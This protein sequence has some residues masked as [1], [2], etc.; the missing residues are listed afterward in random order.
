MKRLL[1]ASILLNSLFPIYILYERQS[2]KWNGHSLTQG[3]DANS[4][5]SLGSL[6][7]QFDP[8]LDEQIRESLILPA[9]RFLPYNLS[10]P[11]KLEQSEGQIKVIKELFKEQV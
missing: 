5:G 9:P 8:A 10:E 1:F 11:Q 6:P 4:K 7:S 3:N 2:D